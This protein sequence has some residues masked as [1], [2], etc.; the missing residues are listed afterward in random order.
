MATTAAA[1]SVT[2]RRNFLLINTTGRRTKPIIYSLYSG[3]GGV[4]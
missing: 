2:A 3:G 4:A 1:V